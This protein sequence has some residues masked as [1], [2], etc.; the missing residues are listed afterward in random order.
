MH[1]A[2]LT[3]EY[4]NPK[5]PEGGL[6]NY[7]RKISLELIQRGH[8]VTIFVLGSKQADVLDQ[9]IELHYIKQA[10]FH[11]RFHRIK[12]LRTWLELIQQLSDAKRLKK[13]VLRTDGTKI[14]LLQTPNYKT[15]GIFL[16]HNK[17]FPVVCR[18]SSY[19]PLLRSANGHQRS[20]SEA[21][22]D[23]LEAR[24]LIEADAVF[25]PSEFI[26][27]VYERF[28]GVKTVLIRTPVDIAPVEQDTLVYKQ[29]LE[30]KPY[31]LFFGALNGVKGVDVLIQALPDVLLAHKNLIVVFIGRND[32]LPDG[33]RAVNAIQK[34]LADFFQHRVFYFPS[35]PRSQL[36]PII[37]HALGV[38]MP[39]RVDNY[40][41]ACLEALSLGVP[42]IGT[43]GSSL[44]EMIE[45][46]KTGF[47]AKNGDSLSLQEAIEKLLLLTSDQ[48]SEI[49]R[50][51]RAEIDQI[52]AEDRISHL[53]YFY[54]RVIND[55]MKY[56]IKK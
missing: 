9:G 22:G 36:Y 14:D 20:L 45:D 47:L 42:V 19:Q 27:G 35:K 49:I 28:E 54:Q 1:L 2:F 51:I 29:H 41:N 8:R 25:S 18:C 3:P 24:Q 50:N 7:I 30:G 32:L 52:Q 5:R 37:S 48:K 38:L 23:W 44:E 43:Y 11:W 10:R 6:G 15:P 46:G 16:C 39:S 13:R 21:I 31:L 12:F 56:S 53:I 17:I 26:A 55:Y 4:P 33:R 34:D 40:P